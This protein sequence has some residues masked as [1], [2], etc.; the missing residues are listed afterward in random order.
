MKRSVPAS[1]P[2]PYSV[3]CGPRSTSTRSMS[4]ICS[5][6]NIGVSPMYIDTGATALDEG[7]SLALELMP[8][9]TIS[10]RLVGPAS[11]K[12]MP[13]T[14]WDRSDSEVVRLC[15]SASEDTAEMLYG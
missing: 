2:E 12:E 6:R 5:D 9:S 15:S 7:V 14:I 1:E 8:R 3:P 4:L 13:A 10:L 11:A